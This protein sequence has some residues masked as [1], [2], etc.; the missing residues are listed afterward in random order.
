MA[1]P[2]TRWRV[3]YAITLRR[4][5]LVFS[6][7]FLIVRHDAG[8]FVLLDDKEVVIDARS[9]REGE[10]A[11]SGGFVEFPCHLARIPS[12]PVGSSGEETRGGDPEG[13]DALRS[14]HANQDKGGADSGLD[15]GARVAAHQ[16]PHG[17]EVRQRSTLSP[18]S[19]FDLDSLLSHLWRIP[20]V[21]EPTNSPSESFEWW[22][23]KVAGDHR[24]FAQVV[25]SPP[26]SKNNIP[27]SIPSRS[28]G[29]RGGRAMGNQRGGGGGGRGNTGR[30]DR[31][32]QNRNLV[33]QRDVPENSRSM[34]GGSETRSRW[35]A[36]AAKEKQSAGGRRPEGQ[37]R[38]PTAVNPPRQKT[39]NNLQ[40][41]LPTAVD[42][43]LPCYNCNT[44]GHLTSLCPTIRCERCGKLGHIRQICQ[45]V[46]PWECVASM[47]G[48]QSPGL[49]FFYFPDSSE[50]K[51]VKERASSIVITVV[52]GSPTTRD[53][54]QEFN[55]YLGTSWRCTARPINDKQFSMRF[56]TPKEVEKACYLGEHMKMRVCNAVINLQPWSATASAKAVLHKAWVRVKNIPTDKRSDAAVAY[57]GSLVG[58]TLE[59]DQA[60]LHRPDYCRILLGCRD[61]DEL[62]PCAEGCLGDYFYDFYYEVESV[63][64]RGPPATKISISTSERSSPNAPSPKRS[65][66]DHHKAAESSEGQTGASQNVTYGKSYSNNLDVVPKNDYEEDSEEDHELL[67]D[68]I[69]REQMEKNQ[70]QDGDIVRVCDDAIVEESSPVCKEPCNV[71]TDTVLDL[72]QKATVIEAVP[73]VNDTSALLKAPATP[74][75]SKEIVCLGYHQNTYERS[76]ASVVCNKEWPSI[77]VVTEVGH[78]YHYEPIVSPVYTVQSP[79]EESGG[80]SSIKAVDN[81]DEELEDGRRSMRNQQQKM[82]KVMDQAAALSK[83]RNLEA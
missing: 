17:G 78:D 57:A 1:T 2:D 23:G 25:A 30:F 77:P 52:K 15:G 32:Q 14:T 46:L 21:S 71:A 54:E 44:T 20:R 42:S 81:N 50:V 68:T 16:G 66:I 51:H 8:R 26:R 41:T 40:P 67:I 70:Q 7:G 27:Q 33:W 5:E 48:F 34:G 19:G 12:H 59:V 49:G 61:I 39:G 6:D 43:V 38:S 69:A 10:S 37:A 9:I 79:E 29:D 55:E 65:R 62:P 47:C 82:E 58:V 36:V 53:L 45:V 31:Q 72:Q 11:E 3:T 63:V 22:L 56:P 76:Y 18:I 28:M 83:K 73:N 75:V 64:V 80:K 24:S 60:T 74:V 4:R 13:G 35:E